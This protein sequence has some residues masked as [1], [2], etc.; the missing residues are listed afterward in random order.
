MQ[1]PHT[2]FVVGA[3]A[4]T[5][6]LIVLEIVLARRRLARARAQAAQTTDEADSV[7]NPTP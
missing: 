2:E 7:W 6:L 5:A 3:Y 4:V 1:N